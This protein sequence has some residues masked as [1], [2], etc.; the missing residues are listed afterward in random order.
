MIE[1]S[2]RALYGISS[3]GGSQGFGAAFRVTRNGSSLTVINSFSPFSLAGYG[4]SGGLV[5][6]IDGSLYGLT[7]QGGDLNKGTLFKLAP[8]WGNL[9]PRVSNPVGH[10]VIAAQTADEEQAILQSL[11]RAAKH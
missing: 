9:P 5:K 10:R 8:T 7:E 4:P 2:D 1:G 11:K 6:D 3:A